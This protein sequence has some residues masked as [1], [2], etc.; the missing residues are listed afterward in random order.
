M[1]TSWTVYIFFLLFLGEKLNRWK[2]YIEVVVNSINNAKKT[3]I[4]SNLKYLTNFFTRKTVHLP[5][6]STLFKY[7]IGQ[8]V[9]V[10]VSTKIR[11]SLSF[12]YSLNPGK[13][14]FCVQQ[15]NLNNCIL[16]SSILLTF[17]GKLDR[18][19]FIIKRRHL[20]VKNSLILPFDRVYDKN[21]VKKYFVYYQQVVIVIY[22]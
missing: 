4:K 14:F 20:F 3:D 6:D 10:D 12:K 11:K 15:T 22:K 5:Y 2:D 1:H 9:M 21:E 19:I 16:F 13:S 7:N 8:R 18:R 17:S